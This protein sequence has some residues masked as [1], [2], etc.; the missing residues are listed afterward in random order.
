MERETYEALLARVRAGDTITHNGRTAWNEEGLNFIAECEG[1]VQDRKHPTEDRPAIGK[2]Q[3]RRVKATKTPPAEFIP[4]SPEIDEHGN[5][6]AQI[7]DLTANELAANL[8]HYGVTKVPPTKAERVE[9]LRNR[10][11]AIGKAGS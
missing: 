6:K 7:E 8:K 5:V 9:A 3:A 4:I 10:L 11:S 2:S 1:G